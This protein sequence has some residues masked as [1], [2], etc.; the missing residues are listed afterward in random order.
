MQLENTP[1]SL[2]KSCLLP[3]WHYNVTHFMAGNVSSYTAPTQPPPGYAAPYTP[4]PQG[5]YQAAPSSQASNTAVYIQPAHQHT[6]TVVVELKPPNYL[7]L[8]IITMVFFCW[9]FGLIGLLVGMQVRGVWLVG[10]V[11][12]IGMQ[13]R[14]VWLVGRVLLIGMQ[15]RGVWGFTE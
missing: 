10:R 4:P 13:V 5:G 8:S 14:G 6:R 11:L 1:I 2:P 9:I 12:L 7:V 3:T 15:V